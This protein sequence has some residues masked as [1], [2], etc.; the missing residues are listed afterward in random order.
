ML[1]KGLQKTSLID[2]PGKIVSI[3][4]LGG[5]NFRCPYCYN[6]QLVLHYQQ[7]PDITE[8]EVLEHLHSRKR[9]LDGISVTGGEPTLHSDLPLFLEKVKK[10][11]FLVKIDTNGTHPEMLRKLCQKGL[12]DYLAMDVKAPLERY[13]EVVRATVDRGKIQESVRLIKGGQVEYEF[14]TTIVPGL[15]D[16]EDIKKI[17]RW[18]EGAKHWVLQQFQP[19]RSID[20]TYCDRKPYSAEHMNEFLRLAEKYVEKCELRGLQENRLG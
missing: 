12:L 3:L 5:C 13:K 17:G 9:F 2:Y 11:G 14:R 7:M 8:E 20:P 16:E 1:I 18:L 4:F 15:L 19:L 6:P 10:E